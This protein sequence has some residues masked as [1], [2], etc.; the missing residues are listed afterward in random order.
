MRRERQ[1]GWRSHLYSG[2]RGGVVGRACRGVG[3]TLSPE[4]IAAFDREHAALL[5]RSVDEEFTV[6]HRI[7]GRI[8]RRL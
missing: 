1:V 3:A 8:L 5:D 7:D 4:E 6:P 2:G